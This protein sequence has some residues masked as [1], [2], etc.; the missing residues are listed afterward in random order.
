M[1]LRGLE[2]LKPQAHVESSLIRQADGMA[3]LH[4]SAL[5]L[6]GLERKERADAG[7]R[8]SVDLAVYGDATR[9]YK[10]VIL[11]SL[12]VGEGRRGGGSSG[13]FCAFGLAPGPFNAL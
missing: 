13:T 1:I 8:I 9:D 10:N 7:A 2:A 12:S 11:N 6:F 4:D 3:G 5:I